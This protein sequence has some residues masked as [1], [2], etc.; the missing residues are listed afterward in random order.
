MAL[1]IEMSFENVVGFYIYHHVLGMENYV[2][3]VLFSR[4]S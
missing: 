2:I 4:L 3:Y 1:I